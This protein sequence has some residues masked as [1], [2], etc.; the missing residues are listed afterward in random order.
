MY[1][2]ILIPRANPVVTVEELAAF[3]RFDVPEQ[4]SSQSPLTNNPGY[5]LVVEYI[6]SATDHV[7]ML[8]A[9]ACI[10]ETILLTF[11][12]FPGR[13]AR[14][15]Y[16]YQLSYAYNWAPLWWYG[17]PQQDSIE[18]IRR[19]VHDGSSASPADP[20]VVQYVDTYGVLQTLDPTLYEVFADKIT[21]LPNNTWPITASRM[22][23]CVRIIYS[24]GHSDTAEGV[25]SKLKSAIK[26]L[27]GW[28][29]D[30]RLPVGVE[31]THEAMLTLSSLL[32]GFRLLR[33]AR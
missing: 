3:A 32:S 14:T 25:P 13:D 2:K 10:T 12:S 9:V 23:D 24:A 17:F 11:D 27:A 18:L 4:F 28:W 15:Q 6:E 30:N 8:A 31:P 20:P 19:P 22:Q 1:E 7:E 33:V 29:Y 21:L 26:F 5:D 16:D